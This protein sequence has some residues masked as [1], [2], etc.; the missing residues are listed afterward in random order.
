MSDTAHSLRSAYRESIVEHVMIG[1]LLCY[2]WEA[3]RGC[4]EVQKPQVDNGGY[5]LVLEYESTVRHVQ[6]KVTC[7]GGSTRKVNVNTGL[8]S[9]PSACIINAV[10]DPKSL[11]IRHYNWFGGLPGQALPSLSGFSVAKHTK[12]DARGNK[13]ARPN[14]RIL[15]ISSMERLLRVDELA[16]RLFGDPS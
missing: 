6:L 1:E 8:E 10:V 9:K 13:K 15:P 4:V 3:E 2:M 12:A 5:D 7:K 11:R 16:E 14:I